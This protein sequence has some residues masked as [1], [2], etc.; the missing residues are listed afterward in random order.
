MTDPSWLEEG[1]A[2]IRTFSFD[3]Y[4]QGAAFVARVAALADER[5]HHPE[6]LLGYKT[7]TVETTSHDAD[8][9]VTDRDR[10]LAQAIDALYLGK[11]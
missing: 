5:N 6:V 9:S 10:R 3:T 4:A 1:G 7:V 11:A 8:N 2:L